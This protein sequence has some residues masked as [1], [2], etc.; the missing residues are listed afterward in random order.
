MNGLSS[1][2]V[3][4]PWIWCN[5]LMIL[6][7]RWPDKSSCISFSKC[8]KNI[9]YNNMPT[10]FPPNMLTHVCLKPPK[11]SQLLWQ[12]NCGHSIFKWN[13]V[14]PFKMNWEF[15]C[16]YK[17]IFKGG[18]GLPLPQCKINYSSTRHGWVEKFSSNSSQNCQASF[19]CED[20]SSCPWM[21]SCIWW[22]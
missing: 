22:S 8:G 6:P 11:T 17:V 21:F 18:K 13:P 20:L 1:E 15:M 2:Q 19:V 14:M 7:K 12:Y 10:I 4:V 3:F 16:N 9:V 5:P